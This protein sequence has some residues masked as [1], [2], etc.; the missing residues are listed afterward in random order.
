[1]KDFGFDLLYM[2]FE[3]SFGIAPWPL[4]HPHKEAGQHVTENLLCAT[5]IEVVTKDRNGAEQRELKLKKNMEA[6]SD[7]P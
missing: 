2:W 1:M 3:M 5:G 6:R 7:L 4:V